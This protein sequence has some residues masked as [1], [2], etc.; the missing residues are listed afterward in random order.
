[1]HYRKPY[2]RVPRCLPWANSRAHDKGCFYRVSSKKHTANQQHMAKSS[3]QHKS[4]TKAPYLSCAA[5]KRTRQQAAHGKR[6]IFAVCLTHGTR[7]KCH[8]SNCRATAVSFVVCQRHTPTQKVCRVFCLFV[9]CL[10]WSTRQSVSKKN[11]ILPS[12]F[13]LLSTYCPWYSMFS[14]GMFLLLL[15]IIILF[16]WIVFLDKSNLNCKCFE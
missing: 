8:P 1:M 3:R 9:V 13:F 15:Y 6:A 14:F 11:L 4:P 5:R 12:D 16:N 2:I 10:K 7:Q